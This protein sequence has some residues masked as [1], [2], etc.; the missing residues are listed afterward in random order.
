MIDI[1]FS[2]S[3][4]LFGFI[5]ALPALV[6][7]A[8][9]PPG[10]SIGDLQK[11]HQES[12]LRIMIVPG[13][14]Q[15]QTG[16][17]YKGIKE[18]DLTLGIAYELADFLKND[19]R[20]DV[21]VSRERSGHYAPWLLGHIKE[22]DE[23]IVA[24]RREA[25]SKVQ[26]LM[27]NGSFVSVSGVGHNKAP[28]DTVKYLY[29]INHYAN[30][31]DVDLVLHIHV[32]DEPRKSR[33]VPGKNTG[34]SIY[35]PETQLPGSVTSRI[36][37]S[38]IAAALDVVA[39]TS[40]LRGESSG[41]VDEQELIA[42]GPWGTRA[43]P[44]LLLEYGY[45]FEPQFAEVAL[46]KMAIRELA[47]QTYLGIKRALSPEFT[48]V[49]FPF[50]SSLL[51]HTFTHALGRG[52][53]SEEVAALQMAL[54]K[55][56]FFACSVQGVFGECTE[57]ALKNFQMKKLGSASGKVDEATRAYLNAHYSK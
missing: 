9:F 4:S 33:S 14:D 36:V 45:I 57:K 22:H 30:N 21:L 49:Q 28:S 8:L 38:H 26:S 46:R 12:S 7:A 10:P 52:S 17:G 24:W 32:N 19:S 29:G 25:Y 43:G 13:H 20:I 6:A 56:G 16:A 39:A 3:N 23:E 27:A 55:E 44:S 5:V 35:I 2:S 51:P 54:R 1:M 41:I 15:K 11:L 34:Y 40:T 18:A 48:D 42:V 50:D 31:N 53:K 37:A 47:F